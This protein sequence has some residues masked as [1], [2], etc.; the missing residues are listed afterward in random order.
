MDC[1]NDE[2]ALLAYLRSLWAT[3]RIPSRQPSS[4]HDAMAVSDERNNNNNN[5]NNS[6]NDDDDEES[7]DTALLGSVSASIARSLLSRPDFV[8][9]RL[10]RNESIF[11]MC[12]TKLAQCLRVPEHLA[13]ATRCYADQ[14]EGECA[15]SDGS[16]ASTSTS[17]TSS[18]STSTTKSMTLET[19]LGSVLELALVL[20]SLE[21][22][23]DDEQTG[24][25]RT[26][27]EE[28]AVVIFP[29]SSSSS[30]S[31]RLR[32]P[33]LLALAASRIAVVSTSAIFRASADVRCAPQRISAQL[34]VFVV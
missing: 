4:D 6:D 15:D 26:A 7:L 10:V 27:Q 19:H 24:A 13:D 25:G 31:L 20:L 16:A 9:D 11:A 23:Y 1:E 34:F 12:C 33:H 22:P 18:S 14:A 2:V 5:N 21:P 8:R 3:C 32:T 30:S 29:S 17:S 28:L